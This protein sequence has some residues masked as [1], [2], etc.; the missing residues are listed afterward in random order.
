MID[1]IESRRLVAKLQA[2]LENAERAVEIEAVYAL[3]RWL[4]DGHVEGTNDRER[5]DSR[6]LACENDRPYLEALDKRDAFRLNLAAVNADIEAYYA[7]LR[8]RELAE[9][10]RRSLVAA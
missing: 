9:R 7:A 8:E 6:L 5:R 10:E 1:L 3:Q 2:Q 4:A